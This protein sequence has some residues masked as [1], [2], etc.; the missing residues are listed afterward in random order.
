MKKLFLY[1]VLSLLFVCFS[2]L[3]PIGWNVI[4]MGVVILTFILFK[5]KNEK[6]KR[7]N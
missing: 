6:S 1:M 7:N 2:S 5:K 3:F 4:F